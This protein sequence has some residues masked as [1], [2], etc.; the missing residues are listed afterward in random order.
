MVL[1]L[2]LRSGA[3]ITLAWLL[4]FQMPLVHALVNLTI[5]NFDTVVDYGDCGLSDCDANA[6]EENPCNRTGFNN[7]TFSIAKDEEI[8][9]PSKDTSNGA[10]VVQVPFN[11][12]AI[13]AF[14]SCN[15][16]CGASLDNTNLFSAINS[17]GLL[18]GFPLE[19]VDPADGLPLA[20][21]NDSL[22]NGPHIL[23][24]SAGVLS[25]VDKFVYTIDENLES[26]RPTS[27]VA[28]ASTSSISPS[29]TS[30]VMGSTSTAATSQSSFPSTPPSPSPRKSTPNIAVILGGACGGL[31]S[32]VEDK[33][34]QHECSATLPAASNVEYFGVSEYDT[35][36]DSLA[37]RIAD[38]CSS[39]PACP[40]LAAAQT[41]GGAGRSAGGDEYSSQPL[42]LLL[43]ETIHQA[44]TPQPYGDRAL[45]SQASSPSP[46]PSKR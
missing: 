43:P 25:M 41:A 38:I 46:V 10:C 14:L 17:T 30:N 37:V 33:G 20:Y 29:L 6:N 15:G 23:I 32:A 2:L 36:E 18:D 16:K 35:E 39:Q 34:T 1:P 12:I 22:S 5:E 8:N 13:Y 28:V 42:L 31:T 21:F 26:S 27:T 9:G 3:A 45:A 7:Q 24:I 4:V 19:N 40:F 44:S 11:G